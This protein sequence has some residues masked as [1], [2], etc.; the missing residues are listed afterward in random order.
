MAAAVTGPEVFVLSGRYVHRAIV[1]AGLVLG[2]SLVAGCVESS[3]ESAVTPPGASTASNSAR[4]TDSEGNFITA[5][6]SEGMGEMPGG[7][8][9]GDGM[10]GDMGSGGM[11]DVEAA[12]EVFTQAGCG[13][14]HVLDEAG[15]SGMIGP[16]L[17]EVA[18]PPE[19]IRESIVEPDAIIT[20]GF[21]PGVMPADYGRTLSEEEIGLLV[22]LLA[23]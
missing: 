16:N 18:G 13:A 12:V 19:M 14:C 21:P 7:G 5:P 23:Q 3:P 22:A 2:L 15:S 11:V 9:G 10:G 8:M 17:N 4:Q 20:E 1:I 6:A